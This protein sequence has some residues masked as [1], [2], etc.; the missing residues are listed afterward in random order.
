MIMANFADQQ[1]CS[2][3]RRDDQGPG[4]QAD[5]HDEVGSAVQAGPGM[6]GRPRA[7]HGSQVGQVSMPHLK[8]DFDFHPDP[9]FTLALTQ[10]LAQACGQVA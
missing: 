6:G 4:P 5:H 10:T 1:P 2:G 7:P 8:Y 9:V 3:C